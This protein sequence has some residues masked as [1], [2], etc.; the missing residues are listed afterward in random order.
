MPIKFK[1]TCVHGWKITYPD[2]PK[3]IFSTTTHACIFAQIFAKYGMPEMAKGF[4]VVDN[5]MYSDLPNIKF[6]Y[7]QRI[8]ENG[9]F[10]DYSF[11]RVE[12]N[13]KAFIL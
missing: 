7:S 2:S 6:Y 13:K 8:G 1:H 4:C 9:E 11:E 3:N 12:S 5:L 10:C